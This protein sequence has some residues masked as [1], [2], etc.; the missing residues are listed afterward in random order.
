MFCYSFRIISSEIG[1]TR[2]PKE[3]PGTFLWKDTGLRVHVQ[4]AEHSTAAAPWTCTRQTGFCITNSS[5][6]WAPT[7]ILPTA[8]LLPTDA[9]SEPSSLL[10]ASW[11]QVS[12]STGSDNSYHLSSTRYVT[13][14]I[15]PGLP[16]IPWGECCHFIKA[17]HSLEGSRASSPKSRLLSC[18]S[19]A[20]FFERMRLHMCM[21]P[22]CSQQTLT[23]WAFYHDCTMWLR[24]PASTWLC[25]LI[26]WCCHVSV[27]KQKMKR[28]AKAL[29]W[30]WKEH[31]RHGCFTYCSPTQWRRSACHK[32]LFLGRAFMLGTQ[33]SLGK[34][35]SCL[36]G[37]HKKLTWKLLPKIKGKMM[38]GDEL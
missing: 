21:H 2:L 23:F 4:K 35:S 14:V 28:E 33:A 3:S 15:S 11:V 31:S 30:E 9:C 36:Q 5:W 19:T 7:Q 1:F 8:A 20:F 18:Q 37:A 38:I 29:C 34:E 13:Y 10:W 26:M 27:Q 22:H 17:K 6:V 24:I 16:S 12:A 32:S 25:M